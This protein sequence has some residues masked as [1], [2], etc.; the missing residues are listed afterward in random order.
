MRII[1]FGD[2][3]GRDIWEMIVAKNDYNKVVFIGD[4]LDSRE[5]IS[6]QKQ[7]DNFKNI[8]AF[9][10][11]NMDKVV[12]LTGNHDY[13]YLKTTNEKYSLYQPLMK[14]NIRELLD[15]AIEENLL[16][17][18][19]TYNDI[20]FTHA[21]VTKTWCKANDIDLNN[22]EKSINDLFRNKPNAFSF[23]SG[24]KT[25]LNGDDISQSPIWVRPRS[26]YVDKI[27]N[28]TFIVGHTTNDT[29]SG[30]NGCR[31]VY[32][33]KSETMIETTGVVFIDTLGTSGEYLQIADDK[34]SAV[35]TRSFIKT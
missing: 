35:N 15:K 22:L 3:H 10:R 19:Y 6:L 11:A 33:P 16:Q 21:G 20:I 13:H 4:Y 5:G 30:L 8:L 32:D 17:I 9:K 24:C 2:I 27:P 34:M 1:A 18:C 12:L 23:E 7:I 26:L 14:I 25:S 28:Y 31:K 29:I